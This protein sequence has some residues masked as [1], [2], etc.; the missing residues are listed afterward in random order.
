M[1]EPDDFPGFMRRIRAGDEDAAAELVRRYEPVIRMEVRLRL[2]DPGL[3]RLFDSADIC[4]SVLAS[5]FVRAA[6]GQYDLEQPGQ[7]AKL[8][9]RMAQNKL[10]SAARKHKAKRR[11]RRRVAGAAVDEIEPAANSP[12]PSREVAGREL[13]A[14]VQEHLRPEERALAERRS[15]GQ[16]WA[17]I[18]AEMGGTADGRRMQ[19]NRALDRVVGELGLEGD[20][21]A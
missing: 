10:A 7:L 12:T 11:D 8:L 17:A 16:E 5:F 21:D 9:T 15:Q 1:P 14:K 20:G 13:L 6:S 18:A 3:Q 19:L 4:Q 2:S